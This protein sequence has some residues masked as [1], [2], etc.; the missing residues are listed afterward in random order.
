MSRCLLAFRTG[1][2]TLQHPAQWCSLWPMPNSNRLLIVETCRNCEILSYLHRK[3]HEMHLVTKEPTSFK[4]PR[5]QGRSLCWLSGRSL[6]A[7]ATCA[8]GMI[9]TKYLWETW[10]WQRKTTVP[11]NT[12][13]VPS[14]ESKNQCPGQGSIPRGSAS[15]VAGMNSN[16]FK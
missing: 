15:G 3:R 6:N 8:K 5:G 7:Q 16:I 13:I 11:H 10:K 12:L 14:T 2:E 1:E 4:M 9:N